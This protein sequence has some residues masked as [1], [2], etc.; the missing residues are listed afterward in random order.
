MEFYGGHLPNTRIVHLTA[1]SFLLEAICG[2]PVEFDG[3]P[4]CPVICEDCHAAALEA[5]GEP[6]SWMVELA[7]LELR[8]AA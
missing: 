1:R 4:E 6:S 7:V 2:E 8:P 3:E 5:G